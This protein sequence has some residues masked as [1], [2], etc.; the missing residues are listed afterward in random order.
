MLQT[1]PQPSL[2][3]LTSTPIVNTSTNRTDN[4]TDSPLVLPEKVAFQGYIVPD[5]SL[6]DL[7]H[8][9]MGSLSLFW[10]QFSL[11]RCPTRVVRRLCFCRGVGLLLQED[12]ARYMF[13]QIVMA[14]DYCHKHHVVHRQ[15]AVLAV[16]RNAV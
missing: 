12:E 8:R 3:S 2:S 9:E 14:V 6:Q 10:C 13:R 7:N 4:F 16:C 5:P 15:V 11:R 1:R